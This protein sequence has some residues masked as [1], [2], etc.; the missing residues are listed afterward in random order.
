MKLF[1]PL[2][3]RCTTTDQVLFK[4]LHEAPYKKIGRPIPKYRLAQC[5]AS[6]KP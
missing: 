4:I 1:C 3:C 5:T 2:F 6:S